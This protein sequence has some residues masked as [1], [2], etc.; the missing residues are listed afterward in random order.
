[1]IKITKN[2]EFIM[3]IKKESNHKINKS[4]YKFFCAKYLRII[5]ECY[6][7]ILRKFNND[8]VKKCHCRYLRLRN[9]NRMHEQMWWH[10]YKL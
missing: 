9:H 1:M 2:V 3:S 4:S 5:E 8:L 6:T 10:R 7:F